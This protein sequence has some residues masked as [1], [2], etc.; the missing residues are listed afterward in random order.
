MFC[1]D[2]LRNCCLHRVTFVQEVYVGDTEKLPDSPCKQV[3]V[4]VCERNWSVVRAARQTV[5][6]CVF[7]AG[8]S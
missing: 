1:G 2:L 3:M 5:L 8:V 6:S 7:L 4:V